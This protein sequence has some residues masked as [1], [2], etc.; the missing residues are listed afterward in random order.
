MGAR[1]FSDHPASVGQ[2]YRQHLV[3]AG[4]FGWRLLLAGIVWFA[5]ALLPFLFMRTGSAIVSDL[6]GR[7]VVNRVAAGKRGLAERPT[8]GA[9]P[10]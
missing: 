10:V 9:N 4:G 6:H 5:H 7:M 3:T 2:T 8:R 1:L